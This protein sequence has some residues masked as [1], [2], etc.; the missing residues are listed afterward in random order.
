MPSR[1]FS[2]IIGKEKGKTGIIMGLGP[3]LNDSI[4]YIKEFEKD[5]DNFSIISCNNIDVM[6]DVKVNYWIL[7]QPADYQNPLHIPLAKHRYNKMGATFLYTDCLD[8]TPRE[9]VEEMLNRI[10]YIGYD[11]RHF[12]SERCG[13]LDVHGRPPTCCNGIIEGRL[14]IQEEFQKYTGSDDS[15][16]S[17][18]TVGVHMVALGVM[19]GLNPIYISGI[20]LDYSNG[21]FNNDFEGEDG[22]RRLGMKIEER[23]KMGMNSINRS[24]DMVDRIIKDFGIINECAKKIGVSIYNTTKQ[25]RLSEV[26]EYKELKDVSGVEI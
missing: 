22:S 11:Q 24:P 2:Y 16:G 5:Q 23:I 18:D 7:A 1:S 14:C 25:S 17:G 6:S 19:L 3:S 26:F 15:Y 8:L 13:W 20:D 10:D 9:E 4:P 21:Y 12:N